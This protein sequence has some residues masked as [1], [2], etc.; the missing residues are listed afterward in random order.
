[1]DNDKYDVRHKKTVFK[2]NIATVNFNAKGMLALEVTNEK[3]HNIKI[4]KKLRYDMN[5]D[6]MKKKR[7]KLILAYDAYDSNENFKCLLQKKR[8]QPGIKVR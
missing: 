8:I 1:M 2:I 6:E 5:D 4:V 3:V 7:I